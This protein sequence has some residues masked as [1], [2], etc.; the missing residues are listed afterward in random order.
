MIELQLNPAVEKRRFYFI[1]LYATTKTCC[2]YYMLYKCKVYITLHSR[3]DTTHHLPASLDVELTSY[4]V[5]E[6]NYVLN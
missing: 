3:I 4:Y 5:A 6:P 2:N 1:F